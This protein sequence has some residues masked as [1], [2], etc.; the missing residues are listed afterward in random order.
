M[1]WPAAAADPDVGAS[2]A[3][4]IGPLSAERVGVALA[5]DAI[6]ITAASAAVFARMDILIDAPLVMILDA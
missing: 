2:S 5:S 3:T 4:L 6:A 1:S